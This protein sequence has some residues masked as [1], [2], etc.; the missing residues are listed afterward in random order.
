MACDLLSKGWSRDEVNARLGHSP[1]LS[2]SIAGHRDL[3]GV[4]VDE[5]RMPLS[6]ETRHAVMSVNWKQGGL[7]PELV[8][9]QVTAASA[10]LFRKE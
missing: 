10:K 6:S 4:F 2:A 8:T 9:Q 5:W 1:Y 7:T 3:S